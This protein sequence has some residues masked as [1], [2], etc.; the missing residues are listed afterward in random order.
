M[1]EV[2]WRTRAACRIADTALFFGADDE[3]PERR[4]GR[5][6]RAKAVCTRC[7]VTAECAAYAKANDI[8]WGVW[9]GLADSELIDGPRKCRNG[10][11]MDLGNT[12]FDYRGYQSCR[13]CSAGQQRRYDAKVKVA[14]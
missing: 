8:R 1:T 4:L 14:A 7:P 6:A 9:A 12:R 10:H 13:A 3:T 11:A 2:N 5:E